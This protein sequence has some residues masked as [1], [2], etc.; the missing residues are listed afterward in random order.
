MARLISPEA[1]K[2]LP[3][4]PQPKKGVHLSLPL[5]LS[6]Q[7]S[8]WSDGKSIHSYP[9]GYIKRGAVYWLAIKTLNSYKVTP[10][11]VLAEEVRDELSDV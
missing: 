11:I 3:R 4:P 7:K 9:A 10:V 6:S 5:S 8:S 1:A 2:I